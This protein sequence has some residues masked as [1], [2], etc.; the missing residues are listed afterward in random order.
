[1]TGGWQLAAWLKISSAYSLRIC[2]FA[3][4]LIPL[5]EIMPESAKTPRLYRRFCGFPL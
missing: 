1:M 5:Q 3:L 4:N 2:D